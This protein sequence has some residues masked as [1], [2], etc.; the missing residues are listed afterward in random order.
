MIAERIW[1]R[2]AS[3]E[4]NL[5]A[6]FEAGLEASLIACLVARVDLQAIACLDALRIAR[7]ESWSISRLIVGQQAR[8]VDICI[9]AL[10][11]R[12]VVDSVAGF[13]AAVEAAPGAGE[14]IR[15]PVL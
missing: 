10:I 6:H 8:F 13:E 7:V 12:L 5:V 1:I 15:A 2:K 11:D 14:S 4:A 9:V 3:L